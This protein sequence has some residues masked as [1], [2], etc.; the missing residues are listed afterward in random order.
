M[1]TDLQA[2]ITIV[3]II[4]VMTFISHRVPT[5]CWTP[6]QPLCTDPSTES[7]QQSHFTEED[8][9]FRGIKI[10]WSEVRTWA[11]PG[12]IVLIKRVA[13]V[14]ALNLPELHFLQ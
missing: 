7:W 8:W 13:L 14:R 2:I 9:R 6:C 11:G 3:I 1:Y 5:M 4:M 10:P 12:T